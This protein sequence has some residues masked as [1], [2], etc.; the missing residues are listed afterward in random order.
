LNYTL[1]DLF[2]NAYNGNS[3]AQ[4]QIVQRFQPLL[5]KYAALLKYED[6]S[7][8]GGHENRKHEYRIR[9]KDES[10]WY[11]IP[12]H[13]PAIVSKELFEQAKAGIR[14]FSIPNKKRHDYPL[15]G[16]VFCGCCDHALSRTTQYPKF[17]CRHSQVNTDFACHGMS[18]KAEELETAV[19]Q[20]IRAQVDTVL[21]VDGDGKDSLDLQMVQQSEYEKKV[22][23]LQ[24]AKRQLYEQF[25]LGE[26]DLG[27][28][29]E[30]KARYDAELVRVK[31]VCTMA[32]AQTK[33][34]QA[35]YEAKV[36]RREIIKE[37]SG[38]DSLTQ[39]LIDALIDKVYV[40]PGNRIEIVYKMQ[41]V[42]NIP[43]NGGTDNE[44][45]VLL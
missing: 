9:L 33:Q 6:P 42:F 20:I 31:N 34:A 29:K 5:K 39:S 30:Q 13:H 35:D 43:G 16:K 27:T 1:F 22:Q 18:V 28:Y 41:D 12:D 45:G 37:V 36:K 3:F 11:K 25:A 21:G 38:A 4:L 32:A 40:F 26:I 10:E 2:L 19:F 15:R 23:I 17:Y 14:R 8:F 7:F 44:S 24:D